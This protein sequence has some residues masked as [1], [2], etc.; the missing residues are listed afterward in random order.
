MTDTLTHLVPAR[1]EVTD[2][3]SRDVVTTTGV[4]VDARAGRRHLVAPFHNS[5]L[6][7]PREG[8]RHEALV[9]TPTPDGARMV[10]LTQADDGKGPRW[11]SKEVFAEVC[12]KA[13]P[14]AVVVVRAPRWNVQDV[15]RDVCVFIG[16]GK[17]YASSLAADGRTWDA[18][19]ELPD[20]TGASGLTVTHSTFTGPV[21]GPQFLPV[22]SVVSGAGG[23]RTVA[24]LSPTE[25]GGLSPVCSYPSAEEASHTVLLRAA[26]ADLRRTTCAYTRA[27]APG[28]LVLCVDDR[29][30]NPREY[31]YP[32][33]VDRVV[34]AAADVDRAFFL[35]QE[36]SGQLHSW[37]LTAGG[38]QV[39]DPKPLH[40]PGVRFRHAVVENAGTPGNPLWSV[41]AV[42]EQDRL[43]AVHQHDTRPFLEDGT[44]HWSPPIPIDRNVAGFGA[45]HDT[46][47]CTSLFHYHTGQD[48]PELRLEVQDHATGTWRENEVRVL[49]GTAFEVTRHRVEALVVTAEGVPLP[50]WPVEVT[51][52][53][54]SAPVEVTWR[55]N[56]HH[57]SAGPTGMT[58]DPTGRITLTLVPTG[59]VAPRLLMRAKGLD[60]P[61]TVQPALA[62]HRYLSGDGRLNPTDPGGGLAPFKGAVLAAA[63]TR[64]PTPEPLARLAA[65]SPALADKAATSVQKVALLG[66]DPDRPMTD[67]ELGSGLIPVRETVVHSLRNWFTDGWNSVTRTAGSA[68]RSIRNGA[69]AVV[70]WARDQAKRLWQ[71]TIRIGENIVHE[72]QLVEQGLETAGHFIANV[73]HQIEAAIEK[74]IDWL[75]AVFGFKDIWETKMA[76]E[77]ALKGVVASVSGGLKRLGAGADTW[78]NG[79]DQQVE[80]ALDALAGQVKGTSLNQLKRDKAHPLL[81]GG[82]SGGSFTSVVGVHHNWMMDKVQSAEPAIPAAKGGTP[83]DTF[84]TALTAAATAFLEAATTTWTSLQSMLTTQTLADQGLDGLI[85]GLRSLAHAAVTFAKAL[86]DAAVGLLLDGLGGVVDLLTTELDLGPLNTVWGWIADLAGHGDD[87]ALTPAALIALLAAF[88]LTIVYK[89]VKGHDQAPFPGGE[90]PDF[91]LVHQ[92]KATAAVGA[93]GLEPGGG[94]D[95]DLTVVTLIAGALTYL[96]VIPV[97]A[98]DMSPEP[99]RWL[100]VAVV[101]MSLIIVVLGAVG[102]LAT[103]SGRWQDVLPWIGIVAQGFGNTLDLI[104]QVAAVEGIDA[105]MPLVYTVIGLICLVV[106]GIE[107][108]D[109]SLEK[110]AAIAAAI[111]GTVPTVCGFLGCPF[112]AEASGETIR[113]L[114]ALIDTLGYGICGAAEMRLVTT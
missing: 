90:L 92:G 98:V 16:G 32:G 35:V 37:V 78:L 2:S 87:S 8:L 13:P 96:Y 80:T 9:I 30:Q 47:D 109:K 51:T 83:T 59:L 107:I 110:G 65:A 64:D 55:G 25:D 94:G 48:A 112:V 19:T 66:M 91:G 46:A 75:K 4:H 89:L 17:V 45:A 82:S 67:A 54:E 111:S 41:Y 15:P 20:L 53:P 72:L 22:V 101:G 44:P 102:Q 108:G 70:D 42:D 40:A 3:L 76:L 14:S 114:R 18:P 39:L 61:F 79:L 93:P 84:V 105:L 57:L 5:A 11:A 69:S 26:S 103:T 81:G 95:A 68:W 1:I 85:D 100:R 71:L 43:W 99:P 77:S 33:Q 49:G 36:L 31:T 10:H 60:T 21:G 50:N 104:L 97:I 29:E 34:A 74:V 86:L 113:V 7:R 52:A 56:A 73:F 12:A 6:T 23:A 63:T 27:E 62:V 88:P 24:C 106:I 28:P 58:T 38:A